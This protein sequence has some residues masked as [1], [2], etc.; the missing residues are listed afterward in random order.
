MPFLEAL[1]TSR[2]PRISISK[3]PKTFQEQA[4]T[5]DNLRLGHSYCSF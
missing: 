3:S 5:Q 1:V 4:E 2:H